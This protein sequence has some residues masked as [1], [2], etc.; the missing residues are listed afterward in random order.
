MA[1]YCIGIIV[2]DAV[3]LLK[4][5]R[6]CDDINLLIDQRLNVDPDS[7]AEYYTYFL[8][9]VVPD[10]P[11]DVHIIVDANIPAAVR[12]KVYSAAGNAVL[13]SRVL[14]LDTNLTYAQLKERLRRWAG[15]GGCDH[16]WY[17]D[18]DTVLTG[19]VMSKFVPITA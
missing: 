19:D 8:K 17:I 5:A 6:K 7:G 16:I 1:R 12:A 15:E 13:N 14:W 3:N 10:T 4:I 11:I 9:G 18:Q 2:D